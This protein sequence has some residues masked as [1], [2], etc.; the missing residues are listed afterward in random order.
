MVRY[1]GFRENC[2]YWEEINPHEIY[3]NM[4][5]CILKVNPEGQGW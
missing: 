5:G 3:G 1:T 4:T 2:R